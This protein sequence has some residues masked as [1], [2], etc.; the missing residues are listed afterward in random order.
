MRILF[1][2]TA[3]LALAA[4]S[5]SIP[6][7]AAGIPD[8]AR[9]VGF[10]DPQTYAQQQALREAELQGSAIPPA[11]AISGEVTASDQSALVPLNA[12]N[13]Q[14]T[15]AAAGAYTPT[16]GVTTASTSEDL[17]R[18]TA[19]A[20]AETAQNSGQPVLHA[21]PSNPAPQT[22]S[23]ARGISA[24]NSFDAVG[25]VRSI[26]ADAQLLAQ[27][28]AQYQVVQPTALPARSGASE[29]NV[30][31][32]ALSTNHNVGTPVYTRVGINKQ[33]RAQRACAKFGSPDRAQAEFL[34]KGGPR[35][36]RLGLDPDGDGF[37]CAWDP[38][39]F[40][41]AVGG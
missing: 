10:G 25:N 33:A 26:D 20:L 22:V 27:N 29:P 32:Y 11:G 30:V 40:R 38:R 34:A 8:P 9:G 1:G 37:A 21:S 35:R 12:T 3:L 36:D 4:C 28:R 2:A 17:A 18:E 39:P 5:T 31:Q 41:A 14:V 7:S 24:E 16:G 23:S 13:Q 6:D 15:A 19:A